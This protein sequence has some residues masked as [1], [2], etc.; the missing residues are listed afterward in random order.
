M[1][2]NEGPSK[3]DWK[4]SREVP[5]CGAHCEHVHGDQADPEHD[6]L[7][8]LRGEVANLKAERDCL[9]ATRKFWPFHVRTAVLTRDME[10]CT[11]IAEHE[12]RFI[13]G[14]QAARDTALAAAAEA[15]RKHDRAVEH[16]TDEESQKWAAIAERDEAR[17][18]LK[19]RCDESVLIEHAERMI[20]GEREACRMIAVTLLGHGNIGSA[21]V[22]AIRARGGG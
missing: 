5:K 11:D 22:R 21:V 7:V 4:A 9:L 1:S 8:R 10:A 19:K 12:D 3:S 2:A 14:L 18:E 17:R 20:E 6:E 15:M 13:A 16:A